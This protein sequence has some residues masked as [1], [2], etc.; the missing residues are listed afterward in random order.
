VRADTR[1]AVETA[2]YT[3]TA[4]EELMRVAEE[5]VRTLTQELGLARVRVTSGVAVETDS[6]QL[7]LELTTARVNLRQQQATTRVDRLALGRQVGVSQPLA[8]EP[9]DSA[10]PAESDL[11]NARKSAR[12]ALATLQARLGRELV[13]EEGL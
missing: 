11:V 13:R 1:V 10:P 6:L 7:M 12:L 5:R 2:Y 4:D 8:A 9:L 3:V